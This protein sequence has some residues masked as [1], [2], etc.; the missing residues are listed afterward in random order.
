MQLRISLTV[1]IAVSVGLDASMF[2]LELK[3]VLMST[4]VISINVMARAARLWRSGDD[5][6]RCER[7]IEVE[8][9]DLL[10]A[11]GLGGSIPPLH[12]SG[13]LMRLLVNAKEW[14]GPSSRAFFASIT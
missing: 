13:R 10:H 2:S 9:H 5:F 14:E 6:H 3:E 1:P 11:S 12:V 4:I 8:S 7:R